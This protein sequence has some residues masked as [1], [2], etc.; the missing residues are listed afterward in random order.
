M[1]STAAIAILRDAP[2]AKFAFSNL[3]YPPLPAD[4]Q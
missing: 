4:L 1:P 2:P 3:E